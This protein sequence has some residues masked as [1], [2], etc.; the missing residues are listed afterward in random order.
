M[1][2]FLVFLVGLGAGALAYY[3]YRVQPEA[4]SD[5]PTAET[6]T[7]D[8]AR[9][10]AHAAATETHAMA[11][12]FAGALT[13]KMAAWHLTH[14]DIKTDLARTGQVVRDNATRAEEQ[15]EDARIVAV[16]RAKFVLDRGLSVHA[17]EV[18]SKDGNVT[19]TGSVASEA[20]VGIA[21]AH[22]LDTEGVH[23][24]VSKLVVAPPPH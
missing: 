12:S 23:Q 5:S 3:L 20:L 19:L 16:I 14:D 9:A 7:M 17:I 8:S 21:V 24:V 22:G 15:A 1:K 2:T 11:V 13:N 6:R 18:I 10:T 4:V